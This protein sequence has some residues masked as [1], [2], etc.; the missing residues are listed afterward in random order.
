MVAHGAGDNDGIANLHAVGTNDNALALHANAGGVDVAAIAVAALHHFGVSSNDMHARIARG[1]GHGAHNG[2]QLLHGQ[3][4]LKDEAGGKHFRLRAG[5][6]EIVDRAVHGQ[7][8]NGAA[9]K[10]HGLHHEG[11]GAESQAAAGQ[12]QQRGIA[13]IFQR[14]IAKGGQ[15]Q[16]LHQLVAEFAATAVAHH[17]GGITLQGQ[18]AG[19]VRKVRL[20][21]SH[22]PFRR[23]QCPLPPTARQRGSARS[24]STQRR[25]LRWRPWLRPADAAACTP[26]QR[27]G[28]RRA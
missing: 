19:P 14:R 10:E 11:V 8:A 9:G 13:Q 4:F 7:F 2:G 21:R 17:D 27:P 5:D 18:R 6:G 12:V 3:A 25:R 26:C 1:L 20:L 16:V 24:Y 28:T 23:A 15:K 22:L